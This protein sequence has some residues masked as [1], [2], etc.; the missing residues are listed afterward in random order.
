[1]SGEGGIG[2][3][4]LVQALQE[5]MANDGYTRMTFRCAPYYT[6]SAFYPVIDHIERLLQFSWGDSAEAKLDKLERVLA[7]YHWPLIEFIPLFAALLS[8]PAP[9]RYPQRQ[10]RRTQA[11]V[12]ARS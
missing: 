1:M 10:K 5:G 9:A 6:H 8:R 11:W 3:S 4:R 2:K 7:G 12:L